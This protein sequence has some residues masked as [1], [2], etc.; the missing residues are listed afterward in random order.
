MYQLPINSNPQ[1]DATILKHGFWPIAMLGSRTILFA[2][3]QLFIVTAFGLSWQQS[4]AWWPFL[5]IVTNIICFFLLSTLVKK[6]GST[7]LQLIHFEKS[8]LKSDVKYFFFFLVIGAIAGFIG[9]FTVS[10]LMYGSTPPEVMFQPLPLWAAI[11]ALFF[12]PVSNALVEI[13]TYFAYCYNRLQTIWKIKWVALLASSFFLAF[14]HLTLPIVIGDTKFMI[15]HVI[16]FLPMA[17]IV[18]FLYIKTRR[19]VP[20]LIVHFLM[21]LQLVVNVFLLSI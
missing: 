17:L 6:E 20:L 10:Y 14:Q 7:Y 19:M 8:Q 4:V 2:L 13:P 5:A 1:P 16:A 18:G 21:D 9:M 15:W 11:L 3:T 12:F